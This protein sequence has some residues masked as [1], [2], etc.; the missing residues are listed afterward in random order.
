MNPIVQESTPVS[1]PG[2]SEEVDQAVKKVKKRK[3]EK[4]AVPHSSTL[5]GLWRKPKSVDECS[6]TTNEDSRR[7]ATGK[8]ERDKPKV[9]A[10]EPVV[11]KL[12]PSKLAAIL[13]PT[14]S[15][16][17]ETPPHSSPNIVPETPLQQRA[18]TPTTPTS[19][20]QKKCSLEASPIESV[21][22]SPRNHQRRETMTP[23]VLA[24]KPHPFFLGK[25]ARISVLWDK[26]DYRTSTESFC[27]AAFHG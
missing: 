17:F 15:G 27:Q 14:Q 20:E 22:R 13:A 26:S 10:K 8:E 24:K 12:T 19:S 16:T 23:S 4:K 5:H 21:R 18:K 9:T 1:A 7:A 11:L 25:E 2:G 6:E 3:L